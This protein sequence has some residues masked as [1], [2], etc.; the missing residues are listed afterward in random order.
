VISTLPA[1]R[2]GSEVMFSHILKILQF[3]SLGPKGFWEGKKVKVSTMLWDLILNTKILDLKNLR[4]Q[5]WGPKLVDKRSV[6]TRGSKTARNVSASCRARAC[7]VRARGRGKH[8]HP[9]GWAAHL[10]RSLLLLIKSWHLIVKVAL[11]WVSFSRK[12]RTFKLEDRFY[13]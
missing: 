13:C 11:H 12:L 1:F 8:T 7:A 10:L 2:A 3:L 9:G 4:F 5:I 6:K